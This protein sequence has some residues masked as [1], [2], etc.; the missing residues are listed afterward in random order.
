MGHTLS[1]ESVDIPLADPHFWTMQGCRTCGA[2]VPWI[3][4]DS[5]KPIY[6]D[7]DISLANVY[8]CC[9]RCTGKITAIDTHWIWQEGELVPNQRTV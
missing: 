2:N 6:N 3:F 1:L 4:G 5:G 8:P 9:R 7:F